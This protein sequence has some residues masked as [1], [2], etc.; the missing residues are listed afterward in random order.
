MF[1]GLN[2]ALTALYAQRR[3]LDVTGQNI[4]NA[5]TEGYTRQRL[6]LRAV[7][8]PVTPAIFA[9]TDGIG[10]GVTVADVQRLRDTFL[11]SRGRVEHAQ[12]SYLTDQKTVHSSLEMIFKEPSDTGLQ[13]QLTDLWSSMHDLANR[14]GDNAT[15]TQVLQRGG[16]IA[17]TLRGFHD[18]L[19][20]LWTSTREQLDAL[21]TEVNTSASTIAQLNQSI[22]NAR[23][24]NL[25]V[26]ELEDQRD[27][28]V[29]HVSEL[30]GATAFPRDDGSVDLLVGGS[31]LVNGRDTRKLAVTGAGRFVDEAT[32]P[33]G[34]KW[35]D[36][37]TAATATGGRLASVLQTLGTTL[38]NYSLALDQ[39]AAN[40]I[41]TVN[42][43]HAA[44]FDLAGNP[45]G[46]F[47]GGSDATTITMAISDPA[48][49]AAAGS[50]GASLDA[51][52]ADALAAI[53]AS[54]SGPDSAYR[55]LVVNLG[56]DTQTINRRASIQAT[57]VQDVD[58]ARAGES[59]VNLDE[60]MTNM[61]TYQRA[62]EAAARVMTAID[63]MLDTLINRTGLVGR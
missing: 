46:A 5:N 15:R 63:G 25:P 39:V 41:T 42:N 37:G 36:T 19:A 57:T 34:L 38:P 8:G 51:R 59:G 22:V 44:G 3:G 43:Q 2:T 53:G 4:A 17:D 16:Q 13:S 6:D 32:S 24:A 9:T 61:I 31:S 11:E 14:P 12:N 20:S 54:T 56:V 28:L 47:F 29:M 33:V 49:L 45:G 50:A 55:Q 26:N 52:N 18:T 23:S 58:G 7:G 21:T 35:V 62:Y 60:E 27:Q 30:T 40:L 10:E 48:K 1:A